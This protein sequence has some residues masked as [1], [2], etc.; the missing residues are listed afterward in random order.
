M[1][2][3]GSTFTWWNGR[4]DEACIF[5][6]L[7]TVLS[8]QEL[9]AEHPNIQ[10]KH[11]IKKGSDRSPLEVQCSQSTEV[12]QKPFKFLNFWIKHDEF[13]EVVMNN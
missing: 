7:D 11:L 13:L 10:V 8:N 4:T 1:G 5:K 12:I 3:N 6:R 9:M 2:Y